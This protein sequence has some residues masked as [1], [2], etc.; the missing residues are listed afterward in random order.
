MHPS[1]ANLCG[2]PSTADQHLLSRS[3]V[4]EGHVD[5]PSTRRWQLLDYNL[6]RWRDRQD[7]LVTKA[8]RDA[9]GWTDHRLVISQMRLRLQPRRMPQGTA[10]LL[11]SDGTTLLTEKSQILKRSAEHFRSVLNGSPA[12]FDAAIDRLPQVDTN[13]DLDLPT[14]L[15][16]TI[17]AVQMISS[18][19]A[20][21]SYAI[22]PDVYKHDG[23]RL[24]AELTTLFQEMWRQG[25]V[26]QDFK[27]VW[28]HAQGRLRPCQPP[29]SSLASG[30][31]DSIM[32][33]S[34]GAV[35][36]AQGYYHLKLINVQVTVPAQP[37][38]GAYGQHRILSICSSSSVTVIV[39]PP[40]E[41]QTLFDGG[42]DS[43][44]TANV[45]CEFDDFVGRIIN[46]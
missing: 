44:R 13:N 18:E 6:S 30:L 38:C 2:T 36:A 19:K 34:S 39:S 11:S 43:W 10:P 29:A 1:S 22:P 24:M 35:A 27:D 12:I 17:R 32:T 15:Q 40:S 23:P 46:E 37:F 28:W 42:I 4:G 9:D 8:I 5:A 41:T 26:P 25:Q 45:A 7:V 20:P 21:G 14:S 31:L 33:P 16:N 3:D